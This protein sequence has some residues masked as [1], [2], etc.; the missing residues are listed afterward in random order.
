MMY[1]MMGFLP[2]IIMQGIFAVMVYPLAKRMQMNAPLWTV[3][4]LIPVIGFII[5]YYI[6]FK[7]AIY[8]LDALNEIK[9]KVSKNI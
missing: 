3:L 8:M 6:G 1:E 7:V 5:F 2:L 4:S 9:D